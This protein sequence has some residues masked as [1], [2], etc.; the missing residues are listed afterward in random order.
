M[1]ANKGNKEYRSFN[2]TNG[3]TNTIIIM[4]LRPVS[5]PISNLLFLNN[6]ACRC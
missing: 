4:F 1:C 3:N 6:R 2:E 5:I